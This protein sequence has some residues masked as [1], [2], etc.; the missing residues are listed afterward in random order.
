MS[1]MMMMTDGTDKQ[2]DRQ[3]DTV[4]LH[5]R[6]PLETGGVNKSITYQKTTTD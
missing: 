1:M 2:T 6:L 4:P 5:K 3:T